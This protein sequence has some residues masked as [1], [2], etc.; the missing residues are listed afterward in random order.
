LGNLGVGRRIILKGDRT[1]IGCEVVY[2]VDCRI[3]GLL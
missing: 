2:S 3:D 1:K